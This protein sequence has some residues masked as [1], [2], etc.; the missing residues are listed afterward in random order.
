MS[1]T[2]S[3]RTLT[4]SIDC[5]PDEV[6]GFASNP[7]NF[8]RWATS[9]CRAIIRSETVWIVEMPQGQATVRFV[10]RNSMGVMDHFV[11]P[12][13]DIEIYVP[14]RIVANGSGSEVIFT[15]FRLP[16]MTD[17]EFATDAGMVAQDLGTLKKL[18]EESRE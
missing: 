18:M 16:G 9:F 17:E 14:V 2:F 7:E 15:L 4:V 12:A 1:K 8:P 13:P 10:P 3:A 5:P 6:Y 11:T